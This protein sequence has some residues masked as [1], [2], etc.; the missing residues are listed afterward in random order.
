MNNHKNQICKFFNRPEGCRN[1]DKCPYIHQINGTVPNTFQHNPQNKHDSHVCKYF[2]N[3]T[4]CPFYPKCA[5]FHGYCE[6]LA[7]NNTLEEHQ[8][9][10]KAIISLDEV[11]YLSS[12]EDTFFVRTG[13]NGFIHKQTVE[14]G[15][16]IGKI[17]FSGNKVIY[18]KERQIS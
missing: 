13:E 18:G 4:N 6:K 3:N 14:N 8:K 16:K 7:F 15:F 10:I 11:K 2:L 5:Y 1:G 9:P 12:D 17:I